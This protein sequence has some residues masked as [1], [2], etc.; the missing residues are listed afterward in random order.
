MS[1]R[2]QN[3]TQINQTDKPVIRP[4]YGTVG[5]DG[6]NKWARLNRGWTSR[7]IKSY[8]CVGC[9]GAYLSC[10]NGVYLSNLAGTAGEVCPYFLRFPTAK[11]S[12]SCATVN[13]RVRLVFRPYLFSLRHSIQPGSPGN[14]FISSALP[15]CRRVFYVPCRK[16]AGSTCLS[17]SPAEGL[18]SQSVPPARLE[19]L[20]WARI[21]EGS[22]LWNYVWMSAPPLRLLKMR[23]KSFTKLEPQE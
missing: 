5:I 9:L 6:L 17:S 4:E 10:C 13:T 2:W 3:Y 1:A 11:G 18:D 22:N 19:V 8:P 21:E 7:V 12:F 20:R 14:I 23:H 16:H 15:N